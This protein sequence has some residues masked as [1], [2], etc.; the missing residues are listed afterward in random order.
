MIANVGYTISSTS[1]FIPILFNFSLKL[2]SFI[3]QLFDINLTFLP[4]DINQLMASAEPAIGVA[5]EYNTPRTNK[6]KVKVVRR[7]IVNAYKQDPRNCS[8]RINSKYLLYLYNFINIL[9]YFKN[10]Y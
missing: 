2:P 7:L 9:M 4:D 3:V 10:N 6:I 5:A 1:D 8:C